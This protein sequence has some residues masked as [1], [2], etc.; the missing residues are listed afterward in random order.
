MAGVRAGDA[1]ILELVQFDLDQV[2][3]IY[4]VDGQPARMPERA[5][6]LHPGAA[7]D[8][9][10]LVRRGRVV[11]SDMFRTAESSLAAVKAGRGAQRPGYSAH[12]LGLA[13]DVDIRPTM[14][15]LGTHTKAE[16]DAV[17]EEHGFFCHRRDH[18]LGHEAWHYTW[19]GRGAVISPKVRTIVNYTEAQIVAIAGAAALAPDDAECQ[20]AL[21]RLRLY[22]GAIDGKIGKLSKAA[23]GAFQRAWDLP[24]TEALT[25]RT[26][27]TL[28]LVAAE[29][30]IVALPAEA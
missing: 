5:R 4:R 22:S 14:K 23:I 26:R 15:G 18:Q 10:A 7:A 19:L 6:Y 3:G 30:K 8:Y 27:R 13:I 2:V 24:A 29:R 12:N 20:R 11:V 21:A 28:A 1:V 9:L 25:A 16:L 17:M